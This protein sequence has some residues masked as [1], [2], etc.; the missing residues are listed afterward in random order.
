MK[1]TTDNQQ[2]NGGEFVAAMKS[3]ALLSGVGFYFAGIVAATVFVGILADDY[4]AL[5]G[6]GRLAAILLAFPIG[7]FSLWRQMNTFG[8]IMKR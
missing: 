1:K 6:K 7:I 3:F 5:N 2:K 8:K 4:F